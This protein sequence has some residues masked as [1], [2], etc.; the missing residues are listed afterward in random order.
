MGVD[1]KLDECM[2][3]NEQLYPGKVQLEA[4][5]LLGLVKMTETMLDSTENLRQRTIVRVDGGGGTDKN[6]D[7]LLLDGY[8][9][10]I[11]VKNWQRA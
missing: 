3:V 10:L 9:I 5:S 6:I 4:S 11:K 1:A 8:W 2:P 7:Q